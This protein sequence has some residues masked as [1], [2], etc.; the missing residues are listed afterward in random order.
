MQ[1]SCPFACL[2]LSYGCF[3][4]QPQAQM[5]RN[6]FCML[7][8]LCDRVHSLYV[9]LGPPSSMQL[10][11]SSDEFTTFQPHPSC[12]FFRVNGE[13]NCVNGH[14]LRS[15]QLKPDAS[16]LRSP[17]IHFLLRFGLV[18]CLCFT[19]FVFQAIDFILVCLAVVV[20][21]FRAENLNQDSTIESRV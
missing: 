4:Y 11:V 8:S 1:C 5:S 3:A 9:M 20:V 14:Y 2:I 15:L 7:N 6:S 16:V 13:T 12:G 19:Q 10:N 18:S 17:C 21:I